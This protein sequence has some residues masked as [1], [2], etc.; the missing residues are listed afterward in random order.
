MT[1]AELLRRIPRLGDNPHVSG[2]EFTNPSRSDPARQTWYF[3]V[4]SNSASWDDDWSEH[5][6]L[7]T[8][9]ELVPTL[10]ALESRLPPTRH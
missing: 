2:Q 7:I 5:L 4:L 3:H 10:T 6:L 8:E 9:A 1:R